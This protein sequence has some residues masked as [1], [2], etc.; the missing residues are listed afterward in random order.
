M[1][2][3]TLHCCSGCEFVVA[4]THMRT[5]NDVRLAEKV[6]EID[7]ILGGHNLV[8]EKRK[9]NGTYILKS[10]SDFRQFSTISLDFR[11]SPVVVEIDCVEVDK[12][13]EPDTELAKCLEQFTGIVEI[14]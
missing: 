9:V 1:V 5:D 10:G 11:E 6:P 12:E 13:Q 3:D 7:L 14:I 4:L 2:S 8:Y